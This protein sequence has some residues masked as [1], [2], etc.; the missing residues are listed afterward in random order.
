[1]IREWIVQIISSQRWTVLL[2]KRILHQQ[3]ISPKN[4]NAP[5]TPVQN[6][7]PTHIAQYQYCAVSAKVAIVLAV[8]G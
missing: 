3:A 8:N 1:M 4:T 7:L 2:R 6:G 5:R